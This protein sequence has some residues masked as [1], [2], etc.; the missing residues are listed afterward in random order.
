MNDEQAWKHFERLA[1]PEL[2]SEERASLTAAIEKDPKL[3]ARFEAFQAMNG[4]P[5]VEPL[6]ANSRARAHLIE[7]L[8]RTRDKELVAV[9]IGR[10]FPVFFGGSVAAALIL[11]LMNLQQFDDLS[12]GTWEALFGI[13]SETIETA[14]VSQL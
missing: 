2:S 10:L 14:L 11:A 7:E 13:P 12:A 3:A 9:N 6:S 8:D 5:E 4:W 1:D